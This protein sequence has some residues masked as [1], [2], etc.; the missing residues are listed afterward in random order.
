MEAFKPFWVRPEPERPKRYYAD[1]FQAEAYAIRWL[2]RL[3]G[4]EILIKYT[5]GSTVAFCRLSQ[6][7]TGQTFVTPAW[8]ARINLQIERAKK[9]PRKYKFIDFKNQLP[10]PI[11]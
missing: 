7:R 3:K 8:S 11:E 2:H 9:P 1:F 6:C 5:D 4:Q 10:L